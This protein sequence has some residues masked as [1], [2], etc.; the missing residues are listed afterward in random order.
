MPL[1]AKP[2]SVSVSR[3]RENGLLIFVRYSYEGK[4]PPR[5]KRIEVAESL[6]REALERLEGG[7]VSDLGFAEDAVRRVRTDRMEA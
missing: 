7:E 3:T 4:L 1:T 6:L 2:L 5:N